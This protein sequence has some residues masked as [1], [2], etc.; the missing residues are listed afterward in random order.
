M[1]AWQEEL[2]Q[3]SIGA[4]SEQELFNRVARIA[5]D[6]GFD[7]CAYGLRAP[8]PF[9]QPR[10]VMINNYPDHWQARYRDRGY[11]AVDPTVQHALRSLQPLVWS[12]SLFARTPE[13]WE[14]ARAAGLAFGWAQPC[15]DATG[16]S[17]MLTLA[18]SAEALHATELADKQMEMIWLAQSAHV[19]MARSVVP[20]LLPEMR[21]KLSAREIEML[22]WT[23]EGKTSS[24]IADLANISK[25]TA[26]FHLN[27]ATAK[28]NAA[29]KTAAAIMAAV[30]GL[31]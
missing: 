22:R 15:R 12:D 23:A 21:A 9:S 31:L 19:G 5:R 7:Y 16:V 10:T 26:D 17:G 24:E 4:L 6:L 2:L 14:E 8:Y 18:R 25:R 1:K 13:L 28:L 20:R 29:N 27:N 11:L 30:L 3:G